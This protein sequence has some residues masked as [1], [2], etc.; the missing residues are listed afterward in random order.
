MARKPLPKNLKRNYR[1]EILFNEAE[2]QNLNEMVNQEGMMI[3]SF[4]R[5]LIKKWYRIKNTPNKQG[6]LP[7]LIE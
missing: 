5:I 2:Y 3:P 7:S 1:C 6:K 4:I